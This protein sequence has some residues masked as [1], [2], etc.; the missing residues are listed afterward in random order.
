MNETQSES[1]GQA[2]EATPVS[3]I[4]R[5]RL[6]RAGAAAVPVALT[7][8]GRSAMAA[9]GDPCEKGLSPL[10]WASL[11]PDR[12]N[13]KKNSHTVTAN[14]V[15]ESPSVWKGK[16][17]NATGNIGNTKLKDAMQS[18]A[19]STNIF[20]ILNSST[21]NLDAYFATAY[22]NAFTHPTTYAISLTELQS[23]YAT[24]K[25]TPTGNDLTTLQITAFLAQTWGG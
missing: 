3:G 6:L 12:T 1:L 4:A 2:M 5:R 8:S 19:V 16:T 7:L 13:C 22:C 9:V 15:G 23:L 14:T 21:T 17:S 24:N 20:A 25:L 11:A 18:G 10:A